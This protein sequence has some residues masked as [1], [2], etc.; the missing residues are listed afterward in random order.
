V[1]TLKKAD[2]LVVELEEKSAALLLRVAHAKEEAKL[3]KGELARIDVE[4]AE[5]KASALTR[6]GAVSVETGG[7]EVPAAASIV[8]SLFSPE[9]GSRLFADPSTQA[10]LVAS[11]G[12]LA[13]LASQLREAA[14]R[15]AASDEAKV[16][17]EV[18][19]EPA[20]AGAKPRWA[21]G[22]P[23]ED[24]EH[25][26]MDDDDQQKVLEILWPG[27][28]ASAGKSKLADFQSAVAVV[29][30]KRRSGPYDG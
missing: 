17:D 11:N 23:D 1:Q 29:A 9:V 12:A 15:L 6:A 26:A 20:P 3:R 7:F 25:A 18:V 19:S 30:K 24:D 16:S 10:L 2:D 4:V 27:I 13:T 8:S 14:A 28:E 21:D 5:C 22:V